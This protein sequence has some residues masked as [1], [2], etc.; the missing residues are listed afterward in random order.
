MGNQVS[1]LRE[2]GKAD[3]PVERESGKAGL[4]VERLKQKTLTDNSDVKGK[5]IECRK[6]VAVCIVHVWHHNIVKRLHLLQ[7]FSLVSQSIGSVICSEMRAR[8][9][10]NIS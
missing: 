9:M 2:S 6:T 3:L 8:L 4:P 1:Q 7:L 5:T 10:T